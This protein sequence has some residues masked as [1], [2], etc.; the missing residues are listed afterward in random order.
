MEEKVT[1]LWKVT[2]AVSQNPAQT[3]VLIT[4]G[5]VSPKYH[6]KDLESNWQ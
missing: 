6:Y 4:H 2:S 1:N 3:S 5:L